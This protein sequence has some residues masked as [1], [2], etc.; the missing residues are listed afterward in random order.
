MFNNL[1]YG[2]KSLPEKIYDIG[3][4]IVEVL[5]NVGGLVP[6]TGISVVNN[7]Y[8]NDNSRTVNQTN[9][10]PKSLSRPEIYRITRNAVN[11]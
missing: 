5:W 8:N 11:V 9:N 6:S 1:V 3:S 4:D 7:Y 2:I 10:S